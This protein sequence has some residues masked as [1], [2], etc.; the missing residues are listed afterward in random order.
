M[1]G[2][3]GGGTSRAP[4]EGLSEVWCLPW[5]LSGCC[6]VSSLA[7]CGVTAPVSLPS[8]P[9]VSYSLPKCPCVLSNVPI[10]SGKV[11]GVG[12]SDSFWLIILG[13]YCLK[14]QPDNIKIKTLTPTS[15]FSGLP[16][17]DWSRKRRQWVLRSL[18]G[19]QGVGL[20]PKSKLDFGEVG[21]LL[22]KTGTM[23]RQ[24]LS[25]AGKCS[26]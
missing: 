17:C 7:P 20:S 14:F 8:G 3:G 26:G 4:V 13:M 10:D 24:T 15:K 5:F 2:W 19:K 6:P 18:L 22:L 9:S 11:K 23:P 25:L 21:P 1:Q 12:V 16:I